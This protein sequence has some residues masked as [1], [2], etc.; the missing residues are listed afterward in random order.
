[1]EKSIGDLARDLTQAYEQLTA[2]Q[3]R[4]TELLEENRRLRRKLDTLIELVD[5]W[6]KREA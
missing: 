6:A 3:A 4:C 5:R 1:M 2:V